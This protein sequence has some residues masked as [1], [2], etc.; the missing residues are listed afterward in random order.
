MKCWN[1]RKPNKRHPLSET[2]GDLTWPPRLPDHN[3]LILAVILAVILA[4]AADLTQTTP[5]THKAWQRNMLCLV[6]K[7]RRVREGNRGMRT[8]QNGRGQRGW[9][10][11]RK[12]PLS[13]PLSLF[14]SHAPWELL[15]LSASRAL[16]F[17]TAISTNPRTHTH[18][19]THTYKHR[20][21]P[22]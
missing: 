2:S 14:L 22:T 5:Q 19:D 11:A 7:K 9:E 8:G 3:L 16:I 4:R 13:Y 1:L 6:H 20:E 10:R 21:N 18:P 12:Q 17:D 15:S